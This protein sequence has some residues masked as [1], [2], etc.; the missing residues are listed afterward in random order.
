MMS[1]STNPVLD[2]INNL[3]V[4]EQQLTKKKLENLDSL[5][6]AVDQMNRSRK[7][8]VT[9]ESSPTRASDRPIVH[10]FDENRQQSAI[11][12]V[13]TLLELMPDSAKS[14]FRFRVRNN[15]R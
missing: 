13:N 10:E 12:F 9:N 11:D 7:Y 4:T 2:T 5:R 15:G 1:H 6:K 3:R 14:Y 8:L